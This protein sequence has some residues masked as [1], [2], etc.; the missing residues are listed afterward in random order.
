MQGRKF[1]A[2]RI[3]QP[4]VPAT[5]PAPQAPPATQAAPAPSSATASQQAK[6]AVERNE[7]TARVPAPPRYL[8]FM[9]STQDIA[10]GAP[11]AI[12]PATVPPPLLGPLSSSAPA[13][14]GQ[15][16]IP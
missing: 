11:A 12:E 9:I 3:S 2:M 1:A 7:K 10:E 5:V 13:T 15:V 14:A 8:E 4:P 16:G 6:S